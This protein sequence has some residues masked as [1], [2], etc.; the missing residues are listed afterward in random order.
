MRD[1]CK[2][3]AGGMV[4]AAM[5]ALLGAS[6]A[7]APAPFASA[8]ETSAKQ[9]FLVDMQT[10]AVLF[11]KNADELMHPASMSKMMTV[12]MLFDQLKKGKLSLD[13]EFPVSQN[14]WRKG[15]AKSGGSTMFLNPG[16]RVRVED[17]LH[18]IIVQSGND[19]CIVAAEAL[20]SSEEAFAEQ[21]TQRAREIGL[22]QSV[23]RNSTG[24]PD[25][26]HVVTARELALLAK[27]TILDFPE[28]YHLYSERVF[29]YN[30]IRQGNRNPL[31]NDKTGV[32]GLKT[33]HTEVSGYGLTASAKRGDRRL[34][35]VL[36]GMGSM[37]ER[38]QESERLLDWGMREFNNYLLFKAGDVVAEGD[39]WLGA[40]PTVPLVAADSILVTMPRV[41]RSKMVVK[42]VF[43]API[44]APIEKGRQV[45]SLVVSAPD[46]REVTVPLVAG[47]DVQRLGVFGRFGAAIKYVL[48]GR[49]S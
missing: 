5:A 19:A 45:A 9:A 48:L 6:F 4:R 42:A 11:E 18:G 12:Y 15:G 25:K 28:F 20:A 41:A 29:T 17:L 14:A 8:M 21:M 46:V 39:T 43:D 7:A 49:S 23:F 35:L 33:G 31:L 13:D 3:V 27:R 36:N 22:K 47:A 37:K 2:Q 30:N 24:W 38:A 16:D 32:D 34:I 1:V 44:K 26:D 10:D 40:E